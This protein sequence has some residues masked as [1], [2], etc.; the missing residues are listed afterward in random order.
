WEHRSLYVAPLSVAGVVLFGF[1][2]RALFLPRRMRTF[3]SLELA[4]QQHMIVTP[5][6][7][8]AA[9][10]IVTAYLAAAYYCLDALYGER[11][12]RSILFW[13]SLP[14]SDLAT[15]LSKACIPLAL[16]PLTGFTISLATQLVM[17]LL[18][19]AVL[20]VSGV[21]VGPLWTHLPFLQMTM[22][23]AYGL[24]VH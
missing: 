23:M 2:I 24:T 13:K 1:G 15:V 5:Y 16:A 17:L 21:G 14:V 9:L 8:A 19:T 6:S 22:V 10:I 3:D 4:K 20:V 11:R 12:D 7:M 18:N